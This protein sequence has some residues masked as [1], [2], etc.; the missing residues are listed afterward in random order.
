VGAVRYSIGEEIAHAATHGVGVLASLAAIPLLV[1][2]AA[3]HGDALR[4][5][6]G[7]AFGVTALLMFV[8]STLYH[9][10]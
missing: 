3:L 6:G 4:I 9:A 7:V 10:V 1:V 8:T 2:T 5:V